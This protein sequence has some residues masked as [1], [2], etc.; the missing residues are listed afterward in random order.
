MRTSARAL[1]LDPDRAVLLVHFDFEDHPGGLWA[2]PGGGL[3]AGETLHDAVRRELLEEVGLRVDE[4]GEPIWVKHHVFSMPGWDGQD[5]TYFLVE[6]D[7]FEPCPALT[8]VELL[9]E[10]VDGIRWWEYDELLRAQTAYDS[11]EPGAVVFSPRGLGHHVATLVE[12][13]RPEK[14]VDVTSDSERGLTQHGG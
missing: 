3:E 7:R 5:D 8:D 1:V 12:L 13:G 14:P 9:A 4:L 11:K 6:S 2:C 10:H